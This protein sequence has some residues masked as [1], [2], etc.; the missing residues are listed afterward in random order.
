MNLDPSDNKPSKLGLVLQQYV[1][2]QFT[3]NQL[4]LQRNFRNVQEQKLF[5]D[6][7]QEVVDEL[8]FLNNSNKDQKQWIKVKLRAKYVLKNK[9]S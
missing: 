8:N 3:K 6:A 5:E 7:W 9:K 2:E 1:V 4:L